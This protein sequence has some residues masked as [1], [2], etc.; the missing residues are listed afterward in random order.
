MDV[1]TPAYL[2][3]V[4]DSDGHITWRAGRYQTPD[5][6]VTNTSLV[7]MDWLASVAGGSVALQR[8]QGVAP[9]GYVRHADIYKWHLTGYRAV[10]VLRAIRPWL[11]IKGAKADLVVAQSSSTW[12]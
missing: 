7:L 8:P 12:R 6:G 9:G 4:L 11:L 10:I 2:A 3:G 5:I 1:G